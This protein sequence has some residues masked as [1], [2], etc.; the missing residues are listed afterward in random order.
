MMRIVRRALRQWKREFL[1]FWGRFTAFHRI[2]M[3]IVL[4]MSIVFVVR[5]RVLDPLESELVGLQKELSDHSIPSRIPEPDQDETVQEERLREE[6]LSRSLKT[7]EAA[8]AE[9]VAASL[10]RLDASWADANALLL[11]LASQHKLRLKKT[12]AESPDDG[13]VPTAAS[14][15][16]LE[17]NYAA[18]YAFLVRVQQEPLLWELRDVSIE[19]LKSTDEHGGPVSPL[20]ALRFTLVQHL[21]GGGQK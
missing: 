4:A 5:T 8:L 16:E 14:A 7:H 10:L 19:L 21:Y 18:I 9:T 2:V 3:G 13:P 12:P 1:A 11:D 20:L 15:C 17:G 6:S